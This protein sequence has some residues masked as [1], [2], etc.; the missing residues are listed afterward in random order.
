[1]KMPLASRSHDTSDVFSFRGS[2]AGG[3]C[4][5][6]Q[7]AASLLLPPPPTEATGTRDAK[8]VFW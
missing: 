5:G 1:M 3:Q 6:T 4:W 7:H 8:L 2:W